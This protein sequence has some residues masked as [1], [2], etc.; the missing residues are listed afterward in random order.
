MFLDISGLPFWA[1]FVIYSIFGLSVSVVV[2]LT[3]LGY[4]FGQKTTPPSADQARVAAVIVE[5]SALLSATEA[6]RELSVE[7][8][9]LT[10]AVNSMILEMARRR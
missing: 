6:A 9:E 8:R 10:R 4:K 7:V 5:P 2:I 1:Q 3:L